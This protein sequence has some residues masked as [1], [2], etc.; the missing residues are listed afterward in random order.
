MKAKKK[1]KAGGILPPAIKK[2]K[3]RADKKKAEKAK[4]S[5]RGKVDEVTVTAK[6]PKEWEKKAAKAF[7]DTKSS[8][9]THDYYV[10]ALKNASNVSGKE[11]Y[12]KGQKIMNDTAKRLKLR[13]PTKQTYS[14]GAKKDWN[15]ALKKAGYRK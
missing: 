10:S 1:Y 9:R 6:A 12:D 3:E 15:K 8:D 2:L 13:N 7:A 11:V 14:G 4:P 5:Y